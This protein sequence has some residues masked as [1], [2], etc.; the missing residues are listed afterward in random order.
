MTHKQFQKKKE[1]ERRV[2]TKMTRRR[3]SAIK[4]GRETKVNLAWEQRMED[5]S[6]IKKVPF[7]NPPS[8]LSVKERLEHNLKILKALEEEYERETGKKDM[9]EEIQKNLQKI[10]DEFAAA[11]TKADLQKTINSLELNQKINS[12]I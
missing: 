10:N 4:V 11:Q 2:K 7:R 12:G 1:R 9:P 6:R 3:E 5:E 8:Q